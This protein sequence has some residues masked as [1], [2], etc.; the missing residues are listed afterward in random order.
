MSFANVKYENQPSH[1]NPYAQ[2]SSR[3]LKREQRNS[4]KL[5]L[6]RKAR[7]LGNKY[8]EKIAEEVRSRSK[9]VS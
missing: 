3:I 8:S 1:R 7:E 5:E 9:K 2:T 4:D 6:L